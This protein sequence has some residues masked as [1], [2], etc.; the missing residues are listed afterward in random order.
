ADYKKLIAIR[1]AHL[2]LSR[3]DYTG[4]SAE[5]DL[6]V[7]LRRDAES[8]D[9]VVVAVNRGTTPAQATIPVPAEWGAGPV[10]DLW[11][12][13]DVPLAG[14]KAEV[15]VPARGARIL[16]VERPRSANLPGFGSSAACGASSTDS[17]CGGDS[18]P[19]PWHPTP[20]GER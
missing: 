13:E 19:S 12:G 5:G 7:Y 15:S 8:K 10:R 14:G 1:R 18:T 2:G 16:A 4:L 3:G 20:Q 11:N 9:A 17:M 6:L